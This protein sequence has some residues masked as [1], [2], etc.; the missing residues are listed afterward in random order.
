[1]NSILLN[2]I[3]FSNI[4]TSNYTTTFKTLSHTLAATC[5]VNVTPFVKLLRNFPRQTKLVVLS[6][7]DKRRI[8][9][10]SV[11]CSEERLIVNRAA[12]F[13]DDVNRATCSDEKVGSAPKRWTTV[14]SAIGNSR[15][16]PWKGGCDAPNGVGET[17][18]GPM[19]SDSIAGK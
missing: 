11:E 2:L 17:T 10:E 9:C 6:P 19:E 4:V 14:C 15:I 13:L 5:I 3:L 16:G 12:T 8:G 1:M 18:L 7:L